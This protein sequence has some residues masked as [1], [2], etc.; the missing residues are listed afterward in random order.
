M[1]SKVL[2]GRYELVE[3][4]GDG[5]MAVVYRAMDK[6]LNRHVAVKIL[7]PQFTED[8]KFIESFRKES[9]AAASLTHPNIVGVYDV[10]REGNINY[11]VM[12]L[13]RGK[14]LSDII[15]EEGPLHYKRVIDISRQIA[16][17]LAAAHKQGIIHRDVKPHNIL[18]NE[19]GIAKIADFG[20]AKAMSVSTIVENTGENII[21]SVHYFSP[22]QARGVYVDERSDIYSLG[23]VM[24]EMLTGDVPFD[25]DNPVNIAL[26]HINDPITPPSQIVD[27]I[28]PALEKVVMKATD[29]VQLN[30]YQSAEEMIEA[31]D[32][33]DLIGRVVGAGSLARHEEYLAED[34]KERDA[35]ELERLAAAEA[36]AHKTGKSGARKKKRA[37]III[38]AVVAALLI[39][40]GVA[41]ASGLFSKK[42]VEVPKL[43][44]KTYQEAQDELK[45]L[46]LDIKEGELVYSDEYEIGQI[47]SQDPKAGSS[48]KKGAVITVNL[49]KGDSN[50]TVPNVIGMDEAS[51][52]ELIV[53]Y[54]YKV[55]TVHEVESTEPAGLV[56]DQDPAPGTE[57]QI[58]TE[59]NLYV[60]NGQGKVQVSV[61]DLKGLSEA[62]AKARLEQEGLVLGEVDHATS[63]NYA[64]DV[65]M[66]QQYDV[67][68]KLDAGSSV[69]ITIST[70]ASSTINYYIDFEPAEQEVFYMTVT[71]T[72]DNGTRNVVSNQQCAKADGGETIAI[73]GTGD[74][75]ILV[76][77]DNRTV[78]TQ[79]VDFASGSLE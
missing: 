71:V 1:S 12:E 6:L 76:T 39:F 14:A 17:G 29:K 49:S 66:S 58:N 24:Y 9:H 33:M 60:S 31:L 64:K 67:G 68:T 22:E 16:S 4:I 53:K 70:G 54:E 59:I 73:K 46:G 19:D 7:K 38:G 44:G 47:V 40:L 30:R 21:G 2:A 18:I 15:R 34:R 23:I 69:S 20:I 32:E 25:G 50:D 43:T 36:A 37:L 63:K 26:M 56:I 75:S 77:F 3:K 13:V 61:P 55:G 27:G 11:I 10:G 42:E 48:V 62:E 28:P 72:D 45:E 74:G 79:N 65:V 5:G 8:E 41:L 35:A 57:A 78:Y 52:R 51:A